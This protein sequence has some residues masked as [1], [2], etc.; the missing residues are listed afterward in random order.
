[1]RRSTIAE[2]TETL[3]FPI[4]LPEPPPSPVEP[5]AVVFDSDRRGLGPRRV[6]LT[7]AVASEESR[8]QLR[9][10]LAGS[11]LPRT[12]EAWDRRGDVEVS[13]ERFGDVA[14]AKVR[15]QLGPTHV[16]LESSALAVDRLIEIAASLVPIAPAP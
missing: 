3:D 14:R 4:L 11:P 7:Y 15:R 10:T 12:G 13:T 2:L 1:M 5:H 9:L 8:G 6:V 16:E